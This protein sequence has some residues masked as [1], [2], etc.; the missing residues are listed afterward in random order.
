MEREER[1]RVG[2]RER[3]GWILKIRNLLK[4]EKRK[5]KI[6]ASHLDLLAHEVPALST[7]LL[8]PYTLPPWLIFPTV[9]RRSQSVEL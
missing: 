6:N 9:E 7:Q 8:L 5:E 3:E 1:E 2:G 4:R